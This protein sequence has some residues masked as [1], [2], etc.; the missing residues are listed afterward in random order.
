MPIYEIICPDCGY[1]GEVLDLKGQGKIE[2]PECQCAD[3]QRVIS[4]TSNLTGKTSQTMPGPNDTR[5]CG[6]TP[7]QGGCAGPG[8][9]CGKHSV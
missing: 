4:P 8:S 9:C 6:S 3:T 1:D 2:C 7:D 5:C